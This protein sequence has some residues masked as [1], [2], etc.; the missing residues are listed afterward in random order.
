MSVAVRIFPEQDE[1]TV[2]QVLRRVSG[3]Y[4]T[5][6]E[7]HHKFSELHEAIMQMEQ[8]ILSAPQDGTKPETVLDGIA[9]ETLARTNEAYRFWQTRLEEQFAHRVVKDGL[10][11]QDYLLYE[12]FSALVKGEL[13][14]TSR[15]AFQRILFLGSGALPISAL[16]LHSETGAPVDCV[17]R[18]SSAIE[19]S[20]KVVESYGV[21]GAVTVLGGEDSDYDIQNYDLIVIGILFKPKKSVLKT[22]RKRSQPGCQVL[23]R[24]SRGIGQVIYESISDRERRGFYLKAQQ[25]AQ[26][27]QAISTWLLEAAGSAAADIRLE[28][29]HNVDSETGRKLLRLMNRTLAE[30]TT[31]GFPGPIDDETGS[32][33]MQ[34]LN[35]DVESRHRYVL[36]AYKD[37]AI[38]GQLIL[39]PNSSPN[40]QHIV[41][42]TRGTIDPSFRGGGLALRAF[43]EIAIKCEELNREVICLDVRAGTHAALWWQHFGFKQYGLLVDYSRADG[44][45]YQGLY[46]TQ[47][48]EELKERLRELRGEKT[49]ASAGADSTTVK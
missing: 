18:D 4:E 41:E 8:F 25:L 7:N 2:S 22:I 47:T 28:W 35:K 9:P 39:T 30:E 26:G 24:T 14:L 11:L 21:G 31:I 49:K 46:L 45:R 44:K 40:H 3:S 27:Q 48:T 6:R 13:A 5:V 15:T 23:C 37:D 34:Q 42:L 33:L 16:L 43:Q 17:A 36:V 12:R 1:G 19:L 38:V 32:R 20:R 29:L 10:A